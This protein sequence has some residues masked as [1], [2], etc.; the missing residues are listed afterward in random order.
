MRF[1]ISLYVLVF[2]SILLV[3]YMLK[4]HIKLLLELKTDVPRGTSVKISVY[5][6]TWNNIYNMCFAKFTFNISRRLLYSRN[7]IRN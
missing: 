7:R 2:I 6:S 4:C 1:F 3:F 5:C